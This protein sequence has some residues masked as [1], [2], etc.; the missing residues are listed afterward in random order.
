MTEITLRSMKIPV[1]GYFKS[2]IRH[3]RL[4]EY[5]PCGSTTPSTEWLSFGGNDGIPLLSYTFAFVAESARSRNKRAHSLQYVRVFTE[6]EAFP[7]QV[8][9]SCILSKFLL[10]QHF[11]T[12]SNE[13]I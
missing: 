12:T 10:L 8:A 5:G 3:V 2:G 6:M 1:N 7:V 13:N 4:P 11:A 9:H